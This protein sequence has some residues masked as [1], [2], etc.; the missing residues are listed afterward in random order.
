MAEYS[1]GVRYNKQEQL[2]NRHI[3]MNAT[4]QKVLWNG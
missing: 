2:R 3:I 4:V 1:H